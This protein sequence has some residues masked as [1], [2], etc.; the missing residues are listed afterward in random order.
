MTR[1]YEKLWQGVYRLRNDK[2]LSAA[3][4]TQLTDVETEGNGLLTYDRAVVKPDLARAAAAAS[5]DF[6]HVPR[7]AAI[8][9]SSLEA[10][11]TWR[12]TIEKP[13]DDWMKPEFK[14]ADWKQGQGAF[15]ANIP[16]A[17]IRTEWKTDDIWLRREATLPADAFPDPYLSMFHDDDAEVYFDGVLAAKVASYNVGYEETPIAPEALAVLQPGRK[18]LI[19]VHCH[20]RT[21][22]QYIDVGLSATLPAAP[23]FH[24]DYFGKMPRAWVEIVK[25][26]PERRV[27]TVRTKQGEV[28]DVPL[29]GDTEMRV[30]DSWGDLTD[31]Y[32]GESVM[33]FMY[34]D[35]AGQWAYPRAVQD[36]IQLNSS[37]KRW[38]TVDA[39]D[40]KRGTVALSRKD[41]QG[42]TIQETF[43]VGDETKVWKGDK[44]TGPDALKVGDVVL[45]QT[46]FD[47]GQKER[48]AVELM[49]EKGLEAVRAEQKAKHEKRLA[50]TGLP[51]VVNDVD[52]LTGAV[53]AT[54]QWEAAD[55]ARAIKPGSV[56]I[57]RFDG[58]QPVKEFTTLVVENKPA[59]EREQLV[60]SADPAAVSTLRVGDE[61]RVFPRPLK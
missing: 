14:D 40:A 27:L 50:E 51:A 7:E 25:I 36:E 28:R 24:G 58:R 15:G 59:G 34:I 4:Y 21:G 37:H 49:D 46:R 42:K 30:R 1:K 6:S 55:E 12:Y 22:G 9:P 23:A 60:L 11:Q 26:D 20:Q 41:E 31:L 16:G 39:L 56:E 29:H 61:V 18:I 32:P 45:F 33:L 10:P 43:R 44:P 17:P 2:G 53:H 47:A 8:V 52:V 57:V 54:V 38:W 48:F 35:G 19:A 13:A 3:V 5:G